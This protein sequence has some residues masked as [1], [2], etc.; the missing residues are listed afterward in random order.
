MVPRDRFLKTVLLA[1]LLVA[2]VAAAG[3][4][5]DMVAAERA[6]AADASARSTRDAF[7]AALAEDGVVFAPGPVNG[8]QSWTARPANKNSSPR[9]TARMAD[10]IRN[11]LRASKP[12]VA[13]C[14]P[15]LACEITT[16]GVLP[17]VRASGP[18]RGAVPSRHRRGS[19]A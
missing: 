4:F 14:A 7:I 6:F 11:G 9:T 1:C 8:K 12:C 19:R 3:D 2:P 15:R 17:W 10:T 18:A 16:I 13:R 5:E